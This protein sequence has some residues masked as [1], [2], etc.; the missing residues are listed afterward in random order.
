MGGSSIVLDS[1]ISI[2]I[3]LDVDCTEECLGDMFFFKEII[4][5]LNLSLVDGK[6]IMS[7]IFNQGCPIVSI[8][9]HF[10]A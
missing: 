6:Y 7:V 5:D 8:R 9:V 4:R 3:F 2:N 1:F 10:D